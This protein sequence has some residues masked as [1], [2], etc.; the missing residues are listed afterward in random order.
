MAQTIIAYL[1]RLYSAL[2][3]E[4]ADALRHSPTDHRAIDIRKYRKL[5]IADEI[6]PLRWARIPTTPTLIRS[7]FPTIPSRPSTADAQGIW[8]HFQGFPDRHE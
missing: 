2:E 6:Q 7:R 5:I 3:K 8:P 4:I 1:E